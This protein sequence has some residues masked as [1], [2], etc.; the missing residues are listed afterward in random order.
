MTSLILQPPYPKSISKLTAANNNHIDKQIDAIMNRSYCNVYKG[1]SRRDCPL[2]ATK[3]S[4]VNLHSKE[5]SQYGD[6]TVDVL[7]RVKLDPD[8]SVAAA[9]NALVHRLVGP[10]SD[11]DPLYFI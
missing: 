3:H 11:P 6:Y 8:H 4:I 2:S 1:I 9:G 5:R 10:G 7:L